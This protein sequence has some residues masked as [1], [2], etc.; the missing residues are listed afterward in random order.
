MSSMQLGDTVIPYSPNGKRNI[1]DPFKENIDS[2][3][4]VA[5]IQRGPWSWIN[6]IIFITIAESRIR[7]AQW[8]NVFYKPTC[9]KYL[10]RIKF[11]LKNKCKCGHFYC[12]WD[13]IRNYAYLW[14]DKVVKKGHILSLISSAV[15]SYLILH[16][17]S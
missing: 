2:S 6:S 7:R 10:G 5:M 14:S 12:M 15:L 3:R 8:A 16:K 13:L 9:T 4:T 1:R 17:V 11:D